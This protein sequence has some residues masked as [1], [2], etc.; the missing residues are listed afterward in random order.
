MGLRLARLDARVP[1]RTGKFNHVRHHAA[2]L[3]AP[4][5]FAY[6]FKESLF[7]KIAGHAAVRAFNQRAPRQPLSLL[8]HVDP[9]V[10]FDRIVDV[11]KVVQ[12]SVGKDNPAI[13]IFAD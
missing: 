12:L 11:V 7:Q 2:Q 4:N 6:R 9:L 10:Q 5:E 3:G 1:A 8:L 13:A